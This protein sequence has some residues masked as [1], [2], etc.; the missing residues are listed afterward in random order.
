MHWVS[1][2]ETMSHVRSSFSERNSTAAEHRAEGGTP[3]IAAAKTDPEQ[4]GATQTGTAAT[5]TGTGPGEPTPTGA[6][7][8]G[9]AL[10]DIALGLIMTA[11]TGEEVTEPASKT[12]TPTGPGVRPEIVMAPE[13]DEEVG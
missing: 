8:A 5:A 9:T 4:T 3:K 6:V 2:M 13:G 10:T 7:L 1:Y 12:A 11:Q